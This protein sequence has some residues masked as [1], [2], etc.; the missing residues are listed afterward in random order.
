MPV[1]S[2]SILCF[3]C[4]MPL[5]LDQDLYT[6]LVLITGYNT[7]AIFFTLYHNEFKETPDVLVLWASIAKC[8]LSL[9]TVISTPSSHPGDIL[10]VTMIS[11]RSAAPSIQDCC[12]ILRPNVSRRFDRDWLHPSCRLNTLYDPILF[13]TFVC[14]RAEIYIFVWVFIAVLSQS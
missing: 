12:F 14:E 7:V 3:D 4:T 10:M 8:P 2:D 5:F 6:H 1:N 9:S 11:L 13:S